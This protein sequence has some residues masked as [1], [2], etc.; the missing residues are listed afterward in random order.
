MFRKLSAVSLCIGVCLLSQ[1]A[2]A[3]E[4]IYL[5]CN[6]VVVIESKNSGIQTTKNKTFIITVES[7]R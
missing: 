3:D 1:H 5:T 7:N 2:N 6:S 4:K